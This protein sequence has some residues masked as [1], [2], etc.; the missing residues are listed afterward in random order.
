MVIQPVRECAHQPAQ[1]LLQSANNTVE[2]KILGMENLL[3]AERQELPDKCCGS[4]ARV[5]D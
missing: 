1:Q 4:L 2:I 3:A 5:L